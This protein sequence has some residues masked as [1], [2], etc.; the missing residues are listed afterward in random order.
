MFYIV[1]TKEQLL[2]LRT[3]GDPFIQIILYNSNYHPINNDVSL[4]YYRSNNKGY[5]LPLEHSE[6]FSL[7]KE[8]IIEFLSKHDKIY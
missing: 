7:Q 1:E 6:A 8:D 5:I 4:L 2:Q 3:N